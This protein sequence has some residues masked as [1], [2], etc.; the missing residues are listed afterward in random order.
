MTIDELLNSKKPE[1]AVNLLKQK[2]TILPSWYGKGGLMEQYEPQ[3]H[4]VMDKGR[5]PD[6]V[7]SDGTLTPVTRITYDLQRLAVKRMSELVCGIPV[8]RIYHAENEKQQLAAK[9]IER[10]FERNRIDAVNTQRTGML[11]ASCEVM[12]LWLSLIHI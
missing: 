4:P 12:T 6:L 8:K 7:N 1:E 10:I 3:R 9:V 2:S 5:Y 11:F